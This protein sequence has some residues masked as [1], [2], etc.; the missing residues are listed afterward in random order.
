MS[1]KKS[2]AVTRVQI[3]EGAILMKTEKATFGT[4]C[5]WHPQEVFDKLRGVEKTEVG[6]MGGK[7]YKE[8]SYEHV[9]SGTTGHAEVV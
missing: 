3:S 1:T 6:F 9:C 8:L 2:K 7:D 5:F 4:G